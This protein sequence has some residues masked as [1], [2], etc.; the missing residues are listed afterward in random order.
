MISFD[1]YLNEQAQVSGRSNVQDKL[2]VV[3]NELL[4]NSSRNR[5]IYTA[6]NGGSTTTAEHFSADLN[7]TLY[8][9]GSSQRSVCLSSQSGI[10][11][12]IA[13][14]FSFGETLAKQ[15][16]VSARPNDVVFLFS[17]S[18]RSSNIILAA[19]AALTAHC[20]V[21]AFIGFDGGLLKERQDLN[22]IYF[23]SRNG[24]YGIIENLHLTACHYV[25]DRIREKT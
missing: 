19:E 5:T 22:I 10:M 14:D 13:N 23:S 18:G 24:A 9:G 4:A 17:A 20:K 3:I 25:I 2:N 15:I 8:K 16:E 7:L 11:T 21:H 1:E 12:A 6:G